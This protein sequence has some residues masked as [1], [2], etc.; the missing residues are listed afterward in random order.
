MTPNSV[1]E[2]VGAIQIRGVIVNAYC[3][4]SFHESQS[5]I[6]C[7]QCT[8]S[9]NTSTTDKEKG[10]VSSEF[11]GQNTIMS[12]LLT[13]NNNNNN[14]KFWTWALKNWITYYTGLLVLHESTILAGEIRYHQEVHCTLANEGEVSEYMHWTSAT[15]H[16]SFD[17][18]VLSQILCFWFLQ[19]KAYTSVV[20]LE[21]HCKTSQN[22]VPIKCHK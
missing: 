14:N 5:Y 1:L 18:V 20:L 7:D 21:A 13:S 17:L 4:I 16:C 22:E 11:Q 3:L 8:S 9:T 10:S 2:H 6:N 12:I 19:L 15:S